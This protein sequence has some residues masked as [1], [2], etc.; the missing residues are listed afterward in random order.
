MQ[1]YLLTQ[2]INGKYVV[3][4]LCGFNTL[5]KPSDVKNIISDLKYYCKTY[6][7]E[8]VDLINTNTIDHFFD[9]APNNKKSSSRKQQK[10]YVYLLR[11][12]EFYKIGYSKCVEQRIQQLDVRPYKI[13]LLMK[14]KSDVAY[15]VEQILHEIYKQYRVDNEW[16]SSELP[17]NTIDKTIHELEVM[18]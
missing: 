17:I 1:D 16:Y 12:G 5:I 9:G 10:G 11:C 8:E 4:T 15:D 7:D 18:M 3:K 14:W 13:K 2:D 6:T